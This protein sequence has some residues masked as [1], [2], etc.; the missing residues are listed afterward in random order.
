MGPDLTRFQGSLKLMLRYWGA[1]QRFR[2][3]G[4]GV[5]GSRGHPSPAAVWRMGLRQGR[6]GPAMFQG[7]RDGS[8]T[9]CKGREGRVK[10]MVRALDHQLDL[11]VVTAE[12]KTG[13]EDLGWSG[14]EAVVRG[15]GLLSLGHF[16]QLMGRAAPTSQEPSGRPWRS[17]MCLGKWNRMERQAEQEPMWAKVQRDVSGC[18]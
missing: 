5:T 7:T 12:S 1:L 2:A 13:T 4:G 14:S 9:W 8:W 10:V 6:D 17:E 15:T 11:K 3:G 16:P 18:L